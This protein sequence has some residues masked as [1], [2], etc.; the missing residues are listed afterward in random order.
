MTQQLPQ[1][2]SMHTVCSVT[3]SVNLSFPQDDKVAHCRRQSHGLLS[4]ITLC[5]PGPAAKLL[6]HNNRMVDQVITS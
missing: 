4:E 1:T 6:R 3:D 5:G 2:V